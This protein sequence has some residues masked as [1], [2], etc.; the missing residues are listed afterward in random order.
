MKAIAMKAI[1]RYW[2]IYSQQYDPTIVASMIVADCKE[3]IDEERDSSLLSAASMRNLP[4]EYIRLIKNETY[5]K[6]TSALRSDVELDP[7][8]TSTQIIQ[9]V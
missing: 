4:S 2:D 9:A 7:K 5:A 1:L 8:L 6:V 3:S